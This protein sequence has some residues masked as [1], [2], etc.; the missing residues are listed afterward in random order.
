MSTRNAEPGHG[1][2]SRQ[3]AGVH[4]V[5]R[6]LLRRWR[7]RSVGQL[8]FAFAHRPRPGVASEAVGFR[9][10]YARAEAHSTVVLRQPRLV[11]P[12]QLSATTDASQYHA[13]KED[14]PE[15]HDIISPL[16]ESDRGEF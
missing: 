9:E 1:P 11:R 16:S 8:A 4:S 14:G 6:G 15:K 7:G 13:T 5:P 10:V 12:L 2:A 3:E